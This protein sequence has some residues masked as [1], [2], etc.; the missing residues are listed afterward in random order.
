[1]Y[2]TPAI[3]EELEA[4][5]G[6]PRVIS[7]TEEFDERGYQLLKKSLRQS[8]YHDV[9]LIIV[10]DGRI[11]VTRKHNYP[12]ST[13]RIPS[14]GI[15]KGEA[16]E[17]GA[18]REAFEETGLRIKLVR[19]LLR[20]LANLT[21]QGEEVDWV[22]HVFLARCIGGE[23]RPIDSKEI[24]GVRLA[25]V[26]ELRTTLHQALLSS[27]IKGLHYRAKLTKAALKEIRSEELE[28]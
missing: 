22:S 25:E 26:E 8:R 19:Y 12:P 5:Y 18:E 23:L 9:T 17:A 4:K 15:H 16:F 2:I 7:L 3:I 28:Q 20:V 13:Y 1:M 21:Y 10:K 24:E 14:G 6:V 27:G 11:V